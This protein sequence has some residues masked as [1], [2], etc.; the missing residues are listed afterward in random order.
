V[1]LRIIILIAS[2]FRRHANI[3]FMRG[4]AGLLLGATASAAAPALAADS[5]VRYAGTATVRH[6]SRFLYG[7]EHYLRYRD[8][9][10][11]SRLVLYTC[12][13]GRPFARKTVQYRDL[14]APDFAFEDASNGMREGVRSQGE[15]RTM[16]F[17]LNRAEPERSALVPKSAGLVIDAGFDEFIHSEWESLLSGAVLP[18]TFLVPSRMEQMQFV[19]QRLEAAPGGIPGAQL[20]RMKLAGV[21][22]WLVPGIDVAYDAK[23]R[24]LLSYEGLSNLRDRAGDNFQ[25]HIDFPRSERLASEASAAEAAGSAPLAVCVVSP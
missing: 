8:G 13:D 7:E 5:F 19:V 10:L 6:T 12:G 21:L 11:L 24:W 2:I 1:I 22:G 18:L 25:V 16:W 4:F 14:Q 9:R 15:V 17:R 20:F 23:D 3:S